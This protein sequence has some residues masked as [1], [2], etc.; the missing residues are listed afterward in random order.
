MANITV[1]HGLRFPYIRPVTQTE[2]SRLGKDPGHTLLAI[3]A[4]VLVSAELTAVQFGYV[5]SATPAGRAIAG[6]ILIWV[7]TR[8]ANPS[9]QSSLILLGLTAMAF[10]ILVSPEV[11]TPLM[12]SANFLGFEN[13][14]QVMYAGG[15]AL[16]VVGANLYGIQ[17]IMDNGS[18]AKEPKRV[19]APVLTVRATST[20]ITP[21]IR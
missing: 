18:V 11:Q 17:M 14:W 20:E 4:A 21:G 8:T 13:M 2:S 19:P 3:T 16:V 12:L 7:L 15:A 9:T 1:L 6:L 10:P 5:L